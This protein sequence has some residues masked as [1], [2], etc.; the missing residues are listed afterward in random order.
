APDG[1]IR[2]DG[3]NDQ[4]APDVAGFRA[5]AAEWVATLDGDGQNDP[6]DLPRQLALV[7][8]QGADCCNGVRIARADA[9]PRKLAGR[10]GNRVRAWITGDRGVTDVGCS[11]RVLAARY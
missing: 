7:R 10:V 1:L 6:A 5:A 4:S 2:L 8:A 3:N 9:W 11:T